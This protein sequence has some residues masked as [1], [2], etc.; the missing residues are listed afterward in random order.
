MKFL[1][2]LALLVGAVSL[3][4]AQG[5]RLG[6]KLGGSRSS[7]VRNTYQKGT[8]RTTFEAGVVANIP[9]P[10]TH[11]L[12]LQG[13]LLYTSKGYQIL[14]PGTSYTSEKVFILQYAEVLLPIQWRIARFRSS[15]KVT[16]SVLVEVGPEVAYLV[17]AKY[18]DDISRERTLWQ[19]NR[20]DVGYLAGISAQFN[21]KLNVGL[22]YTRG[23]RNV[24]RAL[25]QE[26]GYNSS[27]QLQA[28]YYIG[29]AS[30]G[31]ALD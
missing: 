17:G 23:L 11:T 5:L 4:Q 25:P 6:V 2:S 15:Q 16:T 14:Y 21:R 19:Y 3:A 8:A 13:E 29:R 30:Q 12:Y 27:I 26:R 7:F 24:Y 9:V 20:W 28:T 18:R 31:P 1:L 22:R 10:Q